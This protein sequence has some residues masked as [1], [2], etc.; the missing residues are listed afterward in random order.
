MLLNRFSTLGNYPCGSTIAS[1]TGETDRG[2]LHVKYE[3][4][5]RSRCD[6]VCEG[7][8]FRDSNVRSPS[9]KRDSASNIAPD[10]A[11]QDESK[12]CKKHPKAMQNLINANT[13]S[14]NNSFSLEA[15]HEYVEWNPI[16]C[17][18]FHNLGHGICVRWEM[19]TERTW[20][21][22]NVGDVIRRLQTLESQYNVHSCGSI[23]AQ[24]NNQARGQFLVE[25]AR[26]V[27]LDMRNNKGGVC[28]HMPR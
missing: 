12:E 11:K 18:A 8:I 23:L 24:S 28:D 9:H 15:G 26:I 1:L 14:N 4:N 27:C 20:G 6:G 19:R 17:V 5:Q 2:W 7:N 3:S 25:H 10:F 21:D 13:G 22:F 16:E